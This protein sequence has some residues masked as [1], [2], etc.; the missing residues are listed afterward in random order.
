MRNPQAILKEKRL[1]RKARVRAKI[2]GTFTRP[3]MS[4]YRSLKHIYVQLID[5][6]KGRTLV[7]CSDLELIKEGKLKKDHN[8]KK[9]EVAHKVGKRVA[10]KALKKGIVKVVF[11]KNWYKFHGRVKAVAD[12]AREGGLKF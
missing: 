4:V 7:S 12:V 5:D 1:R 8:M 9:T 6:E 10:E 3:R 2:S 11:D